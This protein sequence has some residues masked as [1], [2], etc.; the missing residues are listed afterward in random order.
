[1]PGPDRASP[2]SVEWIKLIINDLNEREC[3]ILTTQICISYYMSMI[4][5]R[6][7]F[8]YAGAWTLLLHA[9]F[10]GYARSGRRLTANSLS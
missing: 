7:L 5:I 4:Y 3:A 10:S 9:S 6:R 8:L 1:M 2:L